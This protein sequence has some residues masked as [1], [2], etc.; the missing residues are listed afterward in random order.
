MIDFTD[1]RNEKSW[2]FHATHLWQRYVCK[3]L[4]KENPLLTILNVGCKEDPGNLGELGADNL[5]FMDRDPSTGINIKEDVKNFIQADFLK[6]RSKFKYSAVVLAEVLEH[7]TNQRALQMLFKCRDV[8]KDNGYLL[9]TVPHDMREKQEQYGK[10]EEYFEVVPGITSW[11]QNLIDKDKL[12]R[13]L[14]DTKFK[15]L[16]YETQPWIPEKNI[17]WHFVVARRAE[18]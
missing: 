7:C 14:T 1:W 11:H 9:L 18:R 2:D 3:Q 10:K 6:W 17:F 5:D 15:V 12:F 13:F 16:S 4:L 8:L